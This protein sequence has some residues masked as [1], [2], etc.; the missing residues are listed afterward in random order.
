MVGVDDKTSLKSVPDVKLPDKAE[1]L[2]GYRYNQD[3]HTA[4]VRLQQRLPRAWAVTIFYIYHPMTLVSKFLP[5]PCVP[6]S[7]S[8]P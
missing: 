2:K 3:N 6:G 1:G 7:K 8:R 5:P 4:I